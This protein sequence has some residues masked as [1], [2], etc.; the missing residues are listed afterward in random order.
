MVWRLDRSVGRSFGL[1]DVV[2]GRR[3]AENMLN[4]VASMLGGVGRVEYRP[5]PHS[6]SFRHFQLGR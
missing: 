3:F 4:Y 1:V 5:A 2:R 6:S